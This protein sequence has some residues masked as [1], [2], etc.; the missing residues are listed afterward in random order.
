MTYFLTTKWFLIVKLCKI[1]SNNQLRKTSIANRLKQS[2][3]V[4]TGIDPKIFCYTVPEKNEKE[5][6]GKRI[7]R[8]FMFS[9]SKDTGH[10]RHW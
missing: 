7:E 10:L 6:I 4:M 3:G 8:E 5:I 2:V 9:E 1:N